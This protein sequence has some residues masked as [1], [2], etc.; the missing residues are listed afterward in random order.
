MK[1]ERWDTCEITLTASK[2]YEN[3]F[4]DVELT[5][6]FKHRDSGQSISVNGFYDGGST[7]RI[8][9]M[10]TELG[11]WSYVTE[12]ADSGLD[13]KAGEITCIEPNQPYLHGPLYAK[14]YH[15]LHADGTPRFLISTRMSCPYASPE[16]WKRMTDFLNAH[17]IN[18][19]L[20]IMGGVGGTVKELYGEGLDFWR[21]NLE[22]FQSIDAFIDAMRRADILASPYFYYFNDREQRKMTPEQDKAYIRYG[23]ARFGAYANVMPVLSNEVD[24]KF[25]ERKGQ[26]DLASHDWANEMGTYLSELAVFGVPVAVHNPME[27][28]NAVNPGFYTLLRDWPFPWTDF[29]LRQAQLAAL[30]TAPELSDDIPEQKEPVYSVRG[31][32]R[33]NQL[34]IDLRRFGIPVINEE[35]GYEMY[36]RSA[37]PKSNKINLR[38]WNSQTPDTLIP[39]FWTAVVAGGYVMWGH[40]STYEMD[41]PLP[42]MERSPT[43]GY[44]KILHDFVAALPYWEMEPMNDLVSANE[45]MVEGKP[46]RMNFCLAKPG[47]FYLIF[48][49]NG[50][51]LKVNLASGNTYEAIQMDPRTGQQTGLGRV[52]GGEQSFSLSGKEQVLLL[53]AEGV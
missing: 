30:S 2:A 29:M 33:H 40:Y 6:Y 12:S 7:W 22:K 5:G 37:D 11:V 49:L 16:V 42:G 26:Y 1:V 25:T 45:E 36:G 10:P 44:L 27:T 14:G 52:S 50:G 46:Y 19:V 24:Q 51:E 35:P 3:P 20:F 32:S 43:P 31:Y 34:L 9:F 38:P 41:D 21:Y 4:R 23:M 48:S 18:R 39:T 13:G 15:F 8:R 17:N 28:D 53:R 47:K